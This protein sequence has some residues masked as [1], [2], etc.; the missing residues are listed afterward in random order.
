[1]SPGVS[2]HRRSDMKLWCAADMHAPDSHHD[3]RWNIFIGAVIAADAAPHAA[4]PNGK[5]V[6]NVV[7]EDGTGVVSLEAWNQHADELASTVMG[8][9]HENDRALGFERWLGV[10]LFSVTRMTGS[11][12]E[13]C[14]IGVMRTLP[15]ST[16]LRNQPLPSPPRELDAV[17]A[18]IGAQFKIV[19][20]SDAHTPDVSRMATLRS[21]VNG[22]S[23]FEVLGQLHPPFRINVAG[24][25]SHVSEVQP[26]TG[27]SGK[28][29]RTLVLSDPHGCQITVRQL[30]SAAEDM[31]IQPK[32]HVV[33]YF[34]SGRKAYKLG[35]SG[36]LWAYEDSY[37]KVGLL[38]P[39][40]PVYHTEVRILA[41]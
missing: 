10:E 17:D 41:V 30:G 37:I 12:G 7:L 29:V 8:L 20:A 27:G 33:V 39:S 32:R 34:V 22:I 24:V 18:A 25:V 15:A 9:E 6:F 21:S 1:M 14:P 13:L 5:R 40:I 26:T 3:D 36:P 28:S 23:S 31:E 11:L 4:G 35:D 19:K 38:A 16:S 2:F